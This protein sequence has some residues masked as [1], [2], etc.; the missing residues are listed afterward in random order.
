[1]KKLLLSSLFTMTYLLSWGQSCTPGAN[2]VD[3]TYGIWPDTTQNL[4]PALPNVA[5][6]TDINF[7]VPSTVTA[8]IDPSGQFVGSVI[9]QFTVDAL[10]GLPPGFDFACNNSNCTYLGG[11][12]GCAN[13]FGT[14]D[15]V[16]VFPVAVDVT[17]TVLVVL[18][19]GLPPT[20]VTQSVSFDGYKIVVGSGGQIE[21]IINPISLEPNP[22][23]TNILVSGLL[24]GSTSTL[25]LR[26]LTGKVID[27]IEATTSTASFDLTKLS[28]GT[29]LIEVSDVFGT[30]QQKFVKL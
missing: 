19:P 6:S 5:Y 10:Q 14:T 27:V 3:S 13:I 29:Y 7:K 1:M 30:Q 17:A 16:A 20:P 18:F 24:N 23:S 25:T 8:E 26:D 4:P 12:N 22:A 28:N 11:V 15:S 2:F 9:Q 21:Q